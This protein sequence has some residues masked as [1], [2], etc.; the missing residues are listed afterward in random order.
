MEKS[1]KRRRMEACSVNKKPDVDKS[2]KRAAKRRQ[3]QHELDHLLVCER[4][5]DFCEHNVSSS[6]SRKT[7][8]FAEHKAKV[9]IHNKRYYECNKKKILKQK[10]SYYR[11]NRD[12]LLKINSAYNME[13]YNN[14]KAYRLEQIC[15]SRLR[16]ALTSK[17]VMLRN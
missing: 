6:T 10:R 1:N 16:S 15:R 7:I 2:K 9:A 13:R 4:K 5:K 17:G 8:A 11:K 14:D 3:K 12:H